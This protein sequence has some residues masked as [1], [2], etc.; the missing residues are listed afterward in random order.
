M[1]VTF[2]RL[3][4]IGFDHPYYGERCRDFRFVVPA[5]TAELL[6]EGRLLTREEDGM[7]QVYYEADATGARL[8]D[9]TGRTLRFGLRL[10]NAAFE[11]F[12]VRPVT[13]AALTPVFRNTAAPAAFDPA[14]GAQVASG[15]YVHA[16]EQANRPVTLSLADE[17]GN[18][19][20]TQVVVVPGDSP[21]FDLRALRE[22]WWTVTEDYGAGPVH[23][24]RLLLDAGLAG[25]GIWALA[26]VRIDN[27]FYGAAPAIDVP[28]TARSEPLDYYVVTT[29]YSAADLAALA[30][31]IQDLGAAGPPPRPP[32]TFNK[33]APLAASD[34][35]PSQLPGAL[36][37]LFRSAQPVARREVGLAKIHLMHGNPATPLIENLPQP[38]ARKARAQL[39]IHLS[40]T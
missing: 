37:A 31:D 29:N 17:N 36:F 27:A 9:F 22:G 4:T 35:Q 23:P 39:V 15:A 40:K 3:F 21:A 20:A 18:V 7:L 28:F 13:G 11:N 30:L 12:T 8:V 32:V 25:S 2:K 16:P 34:L 5:A 24:R 6:R 14:V 33:V 10:D 26:E 19:V 1:N 38:T